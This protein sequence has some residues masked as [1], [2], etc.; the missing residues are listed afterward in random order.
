MTE[1]KGSCVLFVK[2]LK[3]HEPDEMRNGGNDS[4]LTHGL[5]AGCAAL[6]VSR[7][8]PNR[9]REKDEAFI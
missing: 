7:P 8:T 9:K 6:S 1:I 4:S 2:S 5:W 3:K